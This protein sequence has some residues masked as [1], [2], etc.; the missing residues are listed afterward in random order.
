M[1]E[2][3]LLHAKVHV[4]HSGWIT[5]VA[6]GSLETQPRANPLTIQL[7]SRELVQLLIVMPMMTALALSLAM[8][9]TIPL[10]FAP[11]LTGKS[12]IF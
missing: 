2:G 7:F 3:V 1:K 8:L 5:I 4:R 12:K 10:S 11:T 9:M 6:V